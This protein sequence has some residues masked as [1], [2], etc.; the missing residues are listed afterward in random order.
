[1][2]HAATPPGVV[3]SQRAAAKAG[4]QRKGCALARVWENAVTVLIVL[5]GA[6]ILLNVAVLR[7]GVDS[8][9]GND[10][11]EHRRS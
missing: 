9:D 11:A 1:V 6:L 10:W 8:R 3:A 4:S 2:Y 5:V 7:F